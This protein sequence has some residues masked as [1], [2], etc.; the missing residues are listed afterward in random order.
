MFK[1][2]IY[3]NELFQ[4]PA[5]KPPRFYGY[6]YHGVGDWEVY[7]IYPLNWIVRFIRGIYIR[8][9][10]LLA[11]HSDNFMRLVLFK[12]NRQWKQGRDAN[13]ITHYLNAKR[14]KPRKAKVW[15]NKAV[16]KIVARFESKQIIIKGE[17]I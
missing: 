5:F 9:I 4:K 17:G 13:E 6:S 11:L 1:K 8:I 7:Y 15:H 12:I 3:G 16:K 2:V 14:L 10:I